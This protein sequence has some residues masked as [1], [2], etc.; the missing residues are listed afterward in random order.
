M[1]KMETITNKETGDIRFI[2]RGVDIGK[3]VVEQ[4]HC[5][6]EANFLISADD[7]KEIV[8]GAATYDDFVAAINSL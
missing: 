1:Q 6:R 5:D 7:L 4:T 8:A 2:K 3:D